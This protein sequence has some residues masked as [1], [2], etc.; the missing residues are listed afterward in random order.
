MIKQFKEERTLVLAKPDGV[1][2]GLAGEIISRIERR[3]LKIVA[4][5]MVQATKAQILKH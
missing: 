5:K 1:K 4:I 2:R 3:G